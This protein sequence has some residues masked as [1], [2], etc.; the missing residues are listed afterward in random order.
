MGKEWRV[1]GSALPVCFPFA[2]SKD[3]SP[4]RGPE[5]ES[6]VTKQSVYPPPCLQPLTPKL[7]LTQHSSLSS[8]LSSFSGTQSSSVVQGSVLIL[9]HRLCKHPGFLAC[10]FPWPLVTLNTGVLLPQPGLGREGL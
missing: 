3:T 8:A 7:T 2:V 10:W 5:R 4:T 9:T 6:R 1:L